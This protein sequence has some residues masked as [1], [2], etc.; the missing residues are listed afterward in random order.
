[1]TDRQKQQWK[2]R[3]QELGTYFQGTCPASLTGD[4]IWIDGPVSCAYSGSSI[5]NTAERPGL[6]IMD[7]GFLQLGGTVQYHGIIYFPNSAGS[8]AKVFDLQGSPVVHGAVFADGGATVNV[9]TSGQGNIDYQRSAFEATRLPGTAG[10]VQNTWRELP[11]SSV[12]P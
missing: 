1:M 3:A 8:T 4:V 11:P 5:Y 9:G 6:L 2:A 10:V 12:A 7:G